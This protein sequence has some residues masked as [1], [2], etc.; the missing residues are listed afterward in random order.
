[1]KQNV[2]LFLLLSP[3]TA[4]NSHF[5]NL[6]FFLSPKASDFPLTVKKHQNSRLLTYSTLSNY[7]HPWLKINN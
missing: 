6:A 2:N 4:I 7:W 5:L 3:V 1:M